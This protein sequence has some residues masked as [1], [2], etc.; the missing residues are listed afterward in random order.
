MFSVAQGP[1]WHVERNVEAD[2][3]S[4]EGILGAGG[5]V[6]V[7]G[8]F[9]V[10]K[11]AAFREFDAPGAFYCGVS[12]LAALPNSTG[13]FRLSLMSRLQH[14]IDNVTIHSQWLKPQKRSW[15]SVVVTDS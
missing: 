2:D 6:G 11:C 15:L 4:I 10:P 7:C 3:G 1:V 13:S 5:C 14:Q 12:I 8:C 9:S